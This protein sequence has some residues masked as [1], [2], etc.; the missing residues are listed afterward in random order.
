VLQVFA[1]E[2]VRASQAR[3]VNDHRIPEGN[4]IQP[5]QFNGCDYI[6]FHEANDSGARE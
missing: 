4:S 5:V 1:V 6:V 2:K 3:G